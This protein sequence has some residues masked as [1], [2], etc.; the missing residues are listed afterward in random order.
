MRSGFRDDV[1]DVL[2]ED[3]DPAGEEREEEFVAPLFSPFKSGRE[4]LL[5]SL[6]LFGLRGR[7]LVSL[8][9]PGRI[10]V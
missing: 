7:R 9:F 3:P 5:L 8:G 1:Y 2:D 10:G 4:K 6:G